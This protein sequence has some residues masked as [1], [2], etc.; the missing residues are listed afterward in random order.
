MWKGH[1]VAVDAAKELKE[2]HPELNFIFLF[3]GGNN[4]IKF[5]ERLKKELKKMELRKI[6]FLQEI[7][8]ICLLFIQ[9]LT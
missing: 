3:V 1:F 9:L 7:F 8:L 4:K 5:F 2:K 6:L